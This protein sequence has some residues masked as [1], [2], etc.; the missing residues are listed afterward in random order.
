MSWKH[1]TIGSQISGVPSFWQCA[2]SRFCGTVSG[3]APEIV[4]PS[5]SARGRGAAPI[6][7]EP[8]CS[9]VARHRGSGMSDSLGLM[10]IKNVDS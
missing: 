1:E 4:A 8:M 5:Q 10:V 6:P 9:S 3:S 7:A 2:S